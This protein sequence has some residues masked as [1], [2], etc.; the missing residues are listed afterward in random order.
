MILDKSKENHVSA[1]IVSKTHPGIV[2]TRYYCCEIFHVIHR[3][4]NFRVI[5]DKILSLGYLVSL[6]YVI[7]DTI[8]FQEEA[9]HWFCN[10][11]TFCTFFKT[12]PTGKSLVWLRW[13]LVA[14]SKPWIHIC[15]ILYLFRV[16]SV[17][18]LNAPLWHFWR[19]ILPYFQQKNHEVIRQKR[20][21]IVLGS[22]YWTHGQLASGFT[23]MASY[24]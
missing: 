16:H 21:N 15:D 20:Q 10:A 7:R 5:K 12:L 3:R 18:F 6:I 17:E 24:F 22:L 8:P 13:W 2:A 19:I 9:Y 14:S 4:I 11:H 23:N 1:K